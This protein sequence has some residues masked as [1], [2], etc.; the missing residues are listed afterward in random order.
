V[1]ALA[2]C[3]GSLYRGM[4]ESVFGDPVP[5]LGPS[6]RVASGIVA[7]VTEKSSRVWDPGTSTTR[8]VRYHEGRFPSTVDVRIGD[9]FWNET[10]DEWYRV[11]NVTRRRAVGLVPD[12]ELELER[13]TTKGTGVA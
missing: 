10:H 9:S 11:T 13:V 4:T 1:Y 12:T 5:N 3:R 7:N 8:V 2:N 6:G